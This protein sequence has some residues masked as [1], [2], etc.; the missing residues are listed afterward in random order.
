MDEKTIEIQKKY[1]ITKDIQS[2]L[3]IKIV[4]YQRV[5]LVENNQKLFYFVTIDKPILI[6]DIYYQ[7]IMIIELCGVSTFALYSFVV[8]PNQ[9]IE[10]ELISKRS[11]KLTKIFNNA[12]QYIFDVFIKYRTCLDIQKMFIF[13]KTKVPWFKNEVYPYYGQEVKY[14]SNL[15]LKEITNIGDTL[16]I[17]SEKLKSSNIISTFINFNFYSHY[18]SFSEIYIDFFAD[19]PFSCY[20]IMIS[21]KFK[22]TILDNFVLGLK[23]TITRGDSTNSFY[24]FIIPEVLFKVYDYLFKSEKSFEVV[25]CNRLSKLLKPRIFLETI[26]NDINDQ[27][28]V[29]FMKMCLYN[30]VFFADDIQKQKYITRLLKES[31]LNKIFH[32]N[33]KFDYGIETLKQDIIRK[34]ETEFIFDEIKKAIEKLKENGDNMRCIINLKGDGIY[35]KNEDKNIL[36]I[37]EEVFPAVAVN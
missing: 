29:A 5:S 17:L 34:Y 24:L 22:N 3:E 31:I 20:N 28:F 8:C 37:I 33:E 12:I 21:D 23:G 25:I 19:S 2:L 13:L 35:F 18:D 11:F 1:K 26:C 10:I 36:K 30:C 32:N 27:Y 14:I 16:K 7:K 9:S 6:D 15:P 4:D